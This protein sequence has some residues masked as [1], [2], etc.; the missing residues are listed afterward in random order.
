MTKLMPR[1]KFTFFFAGSTALLRASTLAA[2]ALLGVDLARAQALTN[3]SNNPAEWCAT[4][5]RSLPGL[6]PA[7]CKLAE[8]Q[9]AS[10]KSVE[11]RPL[12]V[13]D[14]KPRVTPR[15]KILVLGGIHGDEMTSSTIVFDWIER[16]RKVN[17][18][19]IHWRMLP[20]VNPDGLIRQ[21][22]TR[23]NAH[24]VD[25]NRNF[26]TSDWK[27]KSHSYW[28]QKTGSDPRRF[29]GQAPLS[30]PETK[31]VHNHI[32][33]FKPDLIVSIHAPY[34]VLDFDGPP[35]PPSKLGGLLLDQV[36]IYPGSLGNYGGVDKN[37]PVVTVELKH[38]IDP[39]S[40]KE[41]DRM[42][43]DLTE[44]IDRRLLKSNVKTTESSDTPAVY[45]KTETAEKTDSS[46]ATNASNKSSAK[47]AAKA[48]P[49][50]Q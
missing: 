40:T 31:W 24:G 44:W 19:D 29:P 49:S 45:A 41:L 27:A 11:G 18:L 37:V 4:L 47:V 5:S 8:L 16:A 48:A 32:D 2:L 26:P 21:P 39:P 13:R 35:P 3:A 38:A 10:Q 14:I 7:R 12:S 6:T 23:V 36:G 50:R 46:N 9:T 25:L 15:L 28:V 43:E 20:L 33:G 30:E 34:G 42:W 17:T 22:A 1:T